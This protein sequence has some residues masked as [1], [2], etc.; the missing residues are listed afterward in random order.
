MFYLSFC[1]TNKALA[2]S[3]TLSE[4]HKRL[5]T[6]QVSLPSL[7]V[8]Q[9]KFWLPPTHSQNHTKGYLHAR[10]LY[11]AYAYQSYRVAQK[12][13]LHVDISVQ[14]Q[15]LKINNN[16]HQGGTIKIKG[17]GTVTLAR[18][19]ARQSF[20]LICW[21]LS[22]QAFGILGCQLFDLKRG[23]CNWEWEGFTRNFKQPLQDI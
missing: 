18:C 1:N 21:A 2:F 10:C 7:F 5:F 20:T 16:V 23:G 22:C 6:C 14:R 15:G 17:Q 11:Q 9:I 3:N 19:H 13:I 8:I 4:S 12:K